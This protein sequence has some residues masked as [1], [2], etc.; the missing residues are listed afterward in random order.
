M[1]AIILAF[2]GSAII[3]AAQTPA[4]STPARKAPTTAIA[5]SFLF[6]GL[7]QV[8]TESYWKVPLFAGA[9]VT[10]GYFVAVNH[11]SFTSASQDYDA[12]IARGDNS[13]ITNLLLRRREV[14]R[15]NRDVAGLALL[16]TYALAA[17]DAYVGANLYDFNVTPELSLGVGPTPTQT[18]AISMHLRY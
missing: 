2:C 14:Y 4:D 1:R 7:G 6:P 10:T 11:S 16:L 9:A 13:S 8:Y 3:C 18:M 5:Y 17:V 12:A 15:N